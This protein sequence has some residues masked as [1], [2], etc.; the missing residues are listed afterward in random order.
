MND[1]EFLDICSKHGITVEIG[2]Q[3]SIKCQIAQLIN[4]IND[5]HRNALKGNPFCE[6][7]KE[8]DCEV[9]LDGTCRMTRF[10][11]KAKKLETDKEP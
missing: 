11:L 9:S 7:C 6:D 8:T 1:K 4:L 2:A 3:Y 10:Y 5:V